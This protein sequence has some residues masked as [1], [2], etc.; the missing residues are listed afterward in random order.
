[1]YRNIINKIEYTWSAVLYAQNGLYLAERFGSIYFLPN[2]TR[3][4]FVP[5]DLKGLVQQTFTDR[6]WTGLA[7][8]NGD[9]YA[10]VFGGDIY[11]QNEGVGYFLPIRMPH[12]NWTGLS[13]GPDGLYAC[14][15][16]GSVF[17]IF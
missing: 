12:Q 8:Y 6:E 2:T 5:D 11:I 15:R 17:Q 4:L 7:H 14:E 13:S 16:H 9:I 1:M 3:D 10:C